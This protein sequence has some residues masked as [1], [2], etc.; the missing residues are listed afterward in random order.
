MNLKIV[1]ELLELIKNTDVVEIEW[2]PERIHIIRAAGQPDRTAA[3]SREQE[4]S[5]A[6]QAE[7]PTV[8]VTSPLVGTFYRSASPETQP[9]VQVGDRVKKDQVLCVIEAM[10][11]MNEI[12]SQI[13]GVVTAILKQ[14]GE[15]VGYGDQLFIIEE[16]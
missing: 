14:D 6:V 13:D 4:K 10:K 9:F 3:R 1:K 11:L 7:K 5:R 8:T 15:R 16:L 2:T 12:E